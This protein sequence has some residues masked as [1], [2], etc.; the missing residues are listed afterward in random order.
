MARP[1]K[2]QVDPRLATLL[3]AA[4]RSSE[5]AIQELVDNAWDADAEHVLITLPDPVT[6]DL[7]IV[8]DDGSGMRE[9]EVRNEY[10][11]V[12]RDR[13]AAKGDRTPGKRRPV[14]GRKGVGKFAGLMMAGIMRLETRARGQRTCLTIRKDDL[15]AGAELEA[16]PLPIDVGTCEAGEHGTEVI[17]SALDQRWNFPRAD[18][19]KELLALEYGS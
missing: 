18:R 14:K 17:L 6:N 13:R 11:K 9:Q 8:R 5:Q 3:G 1:A 4:Y 2:F 19:L 7:V 12:A 15:H 10:L 16:L